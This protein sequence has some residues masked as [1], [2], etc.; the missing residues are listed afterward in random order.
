[1]QA[2]SS[3]SSWRWHLLVRTF[4]CSEE[5]AYLLTDGWSDGYVVL[6]KERSSHPI[7]SLMLEGLMDRNDLFQ[8]WLPLP[9]TAV[10]QDQNSWRHKEW[11]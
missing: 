4:T 5:L 10:I 8:K 3:C 7:A 9:A 2:E 6:E 11:V 1:M